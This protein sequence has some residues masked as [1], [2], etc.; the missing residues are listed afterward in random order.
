MRPVFI[1][2][3]LVFNFS[4]FAQ[5]EMISNDDRM[6]LIR[7]VNI[8]PMDKETVITNQDV[9]VHQGIIIKIKKSGKIKPDQNTLVIEA[10]GKYLMPGLAEMHAHVPPN[11]NQ[12]DIERNLNLFLLHGITTIRGMLG[13]PHHLVVRA[14]II[15]GELPGPRFYTSGPSL[16]GN[17][18]KTPEEGREMVR[19]Q[20]QEG[21]DF[22]KLHPGLSRKNFDSIADQAHISGIPF[23]G[24]VS[25]DVG[26]WRAAEAGYSTIDHL[27]GFLEGITPGIQNLTANEAGL[28]GIFLTDKIDTLQYD[29]LVKALRRKQTW[30]VPTQALAERWMSPEVTV[31]ELMRSEGMNYM[32]EQTRNQWANA[33]RNF[34][35]NPN[36]DS[37]TAVKYLEIRRRLINLC[38]FNGVGMLLGSDAPQVFNVPGISTHQELEYLVKSGLSPYNALSTGTANVGFF[39]NNNSGIIAEGK[40]SDFLILD[41]NPLENIS[42]TRSISGIMMGKFWIGDELRKRMLKELE[43]F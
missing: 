41:K 43:V 9:L 35:S 21:Y 7:G 17:S 15:N 24:H 40:R 36:Y 34:M 32:P 31:E 33:K 10:K 22:L 23:A 8:I 38:Y 14:Q 16:N 2:L 29:R 4:S 5:N 30:L 13:H 18:V 1:L 6:I 28:F 25:F 42:N 19:K 11:D 3:L 27:D 39:L 20:K 12:K 37:A 26:I